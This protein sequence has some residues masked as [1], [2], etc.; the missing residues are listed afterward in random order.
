MKEKTLSEIPKIYLFSGQ[1]DSY[2]GW[3]KVWVS[4]DGFFNA[5]SDWGNYQ[6]YWG[7]P[8]DGGI[9]AALLA[10]GDDYL[11]D[12]LSYGVKEWIDERA[13]RANLQE[14]LVNSSLYKIACVETKAELL[15]ELN[16]SF[17]DFSVP[18]GSER[19]FD[20]TFGLPVW[21]YDLIQTTKIS[22]QLRQFVAKV[23]PMVRLAILDHLGHARRIN[24]DL[25]SAK[26]TVYT[27]K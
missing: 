18:E 4:E 9:L 10:F 16:S 8:G 19:Y 5:Q 6:H 21:D 15:D 11:L 23:M 17:W 14:F 25:V 24:V 1:T 2:E 7:S 26:L 22:G 27:S 12:K 20:D 13:T 3:F